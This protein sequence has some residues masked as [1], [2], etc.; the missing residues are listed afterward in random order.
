VQ[1]YG[2]LTDR[3]EAYREVLDAAAIARVDEL[4]GDLYAEVRG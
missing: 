4:A 3:R 2:V 1:S